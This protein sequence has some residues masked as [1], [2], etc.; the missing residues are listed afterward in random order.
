MRTTQ[1]RKKQREKK[2]G[3]NKDRDEYRKEQINKSPTIGKKRYNLQ[4]QK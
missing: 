2:K 4:Y 1:K 3:I